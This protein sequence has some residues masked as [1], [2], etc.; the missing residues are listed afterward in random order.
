MTTKTRGKL[1]RTRRKIGALERQITFDTARLA[2]A[3]ARPDQYWDRIQTLN[4]RLERNIQAL[5]KINAI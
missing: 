4:K 5:K 2:E 1:S 3:N